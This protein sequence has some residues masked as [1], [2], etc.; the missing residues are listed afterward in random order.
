[1]R[2]RVSEITEPERRGALIRAY[3][4]R[5]KLGRVFRLAIRQSALYAF[6]PESFRYIDN[7]RGFGF[8]FELS[9]PP[10]GWRPTQPS[11]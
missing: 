11:A 7:A 10:E 6:Q 1:M 5:F 8:K 9:R 3:C 4:E 2:G